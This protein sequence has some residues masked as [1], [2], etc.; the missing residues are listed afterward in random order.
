MNTPKFLIIGHR[1]SGKTIQAVKV[2]QSLLNTF[3]SC[4]DTTKALVIHLHQS[5]E[6]VFWSHF[7][8]A[9]NNPS[10]TAEQRK[11]DITFFL[12]NY[13]KV[14]LFVV[15]TIDELQE[16]LAGIEKFGYYKK[17]ILVVDNDVIDIKNNP[18]GYSV[19]KTR[20]GESM[21]DTEDYSYVLKCSLKLSEGY[22]SAVG[23]TYM[24]HPILEVGTVVEY[25]IP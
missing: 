1:Q 21:E 9:V 7:F 25:P 16:T 18:V 13:Y 6:D 3:N 22:P 24:K 17:K 2:L 19:I 5:E 14:K 11:E 8:N 15:K 23:I 20:L 10:I 12:E 4:Q